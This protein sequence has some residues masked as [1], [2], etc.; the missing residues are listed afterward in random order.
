MLCMASKSRLCDILEHLP[1]TREI[2]EDLL[3]DIDIFEQCISEGD[4]ETATSILYNADISGE[5]DGENNM[6]RCRRI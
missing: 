1:S 3:C 2:N 5:Y 4:I 6:G